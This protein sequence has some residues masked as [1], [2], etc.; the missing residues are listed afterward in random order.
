MLC[1]NLNKSNEAIITDRVILQQEFSELNRE[2]HK[3]IVK[4][5]I[6]RAKHHNCEVCLC[7]N[8]KSNCDQILERIFEK[9]VIN[10]LNLNNV[11]RVHG[12]NISLHSPTTIKRNYLPRAVYLL[13]FPSSDLLK[14][15]ECRASQSL[16]FEIIV[17]DESGRNTEATDNWMSEHDVC[18]LE[19]GNTA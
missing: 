12:Q 15:V 18:R 17:F 1:L 16:A 8:N 9:N 2:L 5:A 3:S 4:Y 19:T 10:K 7:V 11:I 6:D 14:A 13:L